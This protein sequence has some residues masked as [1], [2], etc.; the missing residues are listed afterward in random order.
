MDEDN[1]R[2]PFDGKVR[3]CVRPC[4]RWALATSLLLLVWGIGINTSSPSDWGPPENQRPS[5]AAVEAFQMFLSLFFVLLF[6]VFSTRG[7]ATST[8][9]A[10]TTTTVLLRNS[11]TLSLSIPPTDLPQLP[12]PSVTPRL[13]AVKDRHR[14]QRPRPKPVNETCWSLWNNP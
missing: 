12:L 6:L 7:R 13:A 9:V 4:V 14:Q 2:G 5:Y 10:A 3:A 8:L 1:P 11:H